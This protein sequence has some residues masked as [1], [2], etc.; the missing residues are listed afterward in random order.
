MDQILRMAHSQTLSIINI[1]NTLKIEFEKT[2]RKRFSELQNYFSKV[3]MFNQ[4]K[5]DADVGYVQSMLDHFSGMAN[6]LTEDVGNG[7][8]EF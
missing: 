3:E 1:A 4:Q 2:S 8:H 5:A 7:L 6:E